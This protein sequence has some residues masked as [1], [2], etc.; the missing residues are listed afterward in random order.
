MK[1][2]IK[3]GWNDTL[4]QSWDEAGLSRFTPGR[5]I[6]DYGAS[7]KIAVPE[8]LTAEVSGRLEYLSKP[9]EMPK[10]GDW[11]AVQPLGQQRAIIHAVLPRKS[12]IGRKLPGEQFAKQVLAANVDMAFLVQALDDDFSPER[13]Q[14][15]LFQLH[16]EGVEPILVLNKSD[17]AI[18]IAVKV[19]KLNALNA[20]IIVTS[21]ALGDGID[22]IAD[23]IQPGSTAIF[24]GSSGV[25][26]STI[27]NALLGVDRQTTQTIRE[28]DSKGRHTTT[29]RELFI[30]P[31][32]G[33]VIDTPGLRELQLWGTEDDLA[34]V[35][36]DVEALSRS[37]KFN[38]CTHTGEPNCAVLNATKSGTLDKSRLDSYHKFQK[39]LRFLNAKANDNLAFERKQS[40]KNL[41]KH[42]NHVVRDKNYRKG[43]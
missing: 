10:V 6:A 39:E 31:G 14:R 43:G 42:I 4:K 32:G 15:Y 7:Y 13:L 34:G 29:H 36:G 40:D 23:A 3:L 26:K 27:I 24:L 28:A 22:D 12:E 9:H 37:C 35:F 33:L 38:D 8:E 5:V 1:S 30:L 16:S 21:A 17:E 11:V 20:R 25:G 2:L 19:R 18:D 41:Q